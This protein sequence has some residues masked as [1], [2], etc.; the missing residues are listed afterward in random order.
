MIY[1]TGDTHASFE[2]LSTKNFPE[3]K[4]MTK[5][6]YVIILGDFGGVWNFQ[7][8]GKRELYWLNWLEDKPFTILF[9][10]GNHENYDRLYAYPVKEWNG[11][12][13]HEI[14]S[15]IFHLMRGQVFTIQGK[16]FWTFGGASSRD[17]LDGILELTDPRVREWR[18]KG[19]FFRINHLSWWERELPSIEE[20][21]EGLENLKKYNNKVDFILTHCTASSTQD[22]M[23]E[24][25]FQTDILTEYLEEI[26]SKAEYGYWLFGH[27]H[28]NQNVT[29]KDI[30]MYEQIVRLV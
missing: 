1:V 7:S 21:L 8:S 22:L 6:D 28:I 16:T 23:G 15:N 19:Y 3:Q 2:R 24:G 13:I 9:I 20:M 10:D 4:E 25:L 18:K 17:I 29:T 12:F 30:C 27:Y 5:D 14:R 26:K 11:G